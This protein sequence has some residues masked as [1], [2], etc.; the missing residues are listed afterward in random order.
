M[1]PESP[2]SR[3]SAPPL[4]PAVS[5][6]LVF[7]LALLPV[8]VAAQ[9]WVGSELRPSLSIPIQFGITLLVNLLLGGVVLAVAPRYTRSMV[10]DVR[11]KPGA[12]LVFGIVA[13]L[14]VLVATVLLAITVVGLLVV[15]PGLLVL[16]V[17][18]LA[19]SGIAILAVGSALVGTD[20]DGTAL[21]VGSLVLS[22]VSLVP[23]LG[24]LVDSAVSLVG[25]GAIAADYWASR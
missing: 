18:Q 23:V 6:A 19:A 21:L 13:V 10:A 20:P 9:S 16:T 24:P 12:S 8:P 15:V 4:V 25:F 7:T 1:V 14:A 3:A 5:T 2:Q 17:V 11:E 22:V